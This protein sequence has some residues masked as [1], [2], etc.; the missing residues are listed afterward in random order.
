METD[1][2]TIPSLDEVT[3]ALNRSAAGDRDASNEVWSYFQDDVHRL[4]TQMTRDG[5]H[6]IPDLQATM[7]VNEVWI[8]LLGR[9]M[10]EDLA[11]DEIPPGVSTDDEAPVWANRGHFWGAISRTMEQFLVD[12]YRKARTQKRGG[13]WRRKPLEIAIGELADLSRAMSA[14][15]EALRAALA[16]LDETEP[17]AALVVRHRYLIGLTVKQTAASLGVAPR[18]VDNHWKIG[19]TRLR[20][21]L[22]EA[23]SPASSQAPSQASSPASSP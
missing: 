11:S 20:Q 10:E 19:A 8:R 12:E 3:L 2:R 21:Y 14:D 15:I 6:G 9:T 23:A 18:T 5:F 7:V 1:G 17:A 13:G 16:R 4:A 22:A